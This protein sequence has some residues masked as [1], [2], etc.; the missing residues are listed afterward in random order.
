MK[1][2]ILKETTQQ[3]GS[4]V[5]ECEYDEEWKRAYLKATGRKRATKRGMEKWVVD[6]IE[7]RLEHKNE[8]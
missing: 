6:N 8:D 7:S 3:D 4:L 1:F 5:L 2:N